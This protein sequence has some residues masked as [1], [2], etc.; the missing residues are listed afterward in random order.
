LGFAR[1]NRNYLIKEN[2]DQ[3]DLNGKRESKSSPHPQK[4]NKKKGS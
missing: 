1:N 3:G 2:I 4:S